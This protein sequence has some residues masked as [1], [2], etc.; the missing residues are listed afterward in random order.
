MLYSVTKTFKY[1]GRVYEKG[2]Q[3]F[4][5]DPSIAARLMSEGLIELQRPA[6][7]RSRVMYGMKHAET[8]KITILERR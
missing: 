5:P 7:R 3:T 2:D 6:L 4:I 8:G 1:D